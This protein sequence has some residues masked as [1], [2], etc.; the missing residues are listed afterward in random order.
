MSLYYYYYLEWEC[1]TSIPE[2]E[3]DCKD[4]AR[5]L[6]ENEPGR[7]IN[8]ENNTE[9]AHERW[10]KINLEFCFWFISRS[11]LVEEGKH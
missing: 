1:D 11:Y 10:F 4:I 7:N 5:Q 9:I 6:V 8:V 3:K 2:T